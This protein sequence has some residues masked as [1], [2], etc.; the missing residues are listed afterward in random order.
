MVR[1]KSCQSW[2]YWTFTDNLSSV[3]DYSKS[4]TIIINE[5]DPES[6]QQFIT[7]E[8]LLKER[9]DYFKAVCNKQWKEGQTRTI[10]LSEVEGE[11]SAP[12]CSGYLEE[13][14]AWR[15]SSNTK[16]T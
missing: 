11:P 12:T 7:P 6:T 2:T 5:E 16:A 8:G 14:S 1:P 15:P 9:S 3:P 13:R 4:I 10:K